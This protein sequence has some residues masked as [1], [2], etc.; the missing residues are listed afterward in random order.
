MNVDGRE[1]GRDAE[2]YELLQ[3]QTRSDRKREEMGETYGGVEQSR[4]RKKRIQL[5]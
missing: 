5:K 2:L 1:R 3:A 4:C